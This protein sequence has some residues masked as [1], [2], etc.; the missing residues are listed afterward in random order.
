[1]TAAELTQARSD[2]V[3]AV[4]FKLTERDFLRANVAHFARIGIMWAAWVLL[5]PVM[6][7]ICVYWLLIDP[8]RLQAYPLILGLFM[9]FGLPILTVVSCRKVFRSQPGLALPQ[10]VEFTAESVNVTSEAFSGAEKW[11]LF[12]FHVETKHLIILHQGSKLFRLIPKR[13]FASP[14]QLE[15]AMAIVRGRT[16]ARPFRFMP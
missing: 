15:R 11:S 12:A 4:Q 1:M 8:S 9:T 2:G 16:P 14:E 6:L 3:V 5:G 10:T 13:A 7:G